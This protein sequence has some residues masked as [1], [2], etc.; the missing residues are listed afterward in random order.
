MKTTEGPEWPRTD[1][2]K[3]LKPSFPDYMLPLD[4]LR[5]YQSVPNGREQCLLALCITWE[6]ILGKHKIS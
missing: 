1:T 2:I 5:E 3:I 4:S 6:N